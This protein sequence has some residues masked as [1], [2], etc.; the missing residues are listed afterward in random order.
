MIRRSCANGVMVLAALMLAASPVAGQNDVVAYRRSTA[1]APAGTAVPAAPTS[2]ADC[3]P[4]NIRYCPPPGQSA[5]TTPQPADPKKHK[6]NDALIAILT[7]VAIAGGAIAATSGKA[8]PVDPY[9]RFDDEQVLDSK[10]PRLPKVVQ[11]GQF[12]VE[13]YVRGG[14]PLVFDVDAPT[15][16]QVYLRVIVEGV[17]PG[18]IPDYRLT[19]VAAQPV[20]R[21]ASGHTAPP[22]AIAE[23]AAHGWYGRVDLP[24]IPALDGTRRAWLRI[25]SIRKNQVAPL[26]VYAVGAG[27]EAVGSTAL[28]VDQ[29]DPSPLSHKHIPNAAGFVVRF[30]N[31]QLF[32]QL[33]AQVM[34]QKKVTQGGYQRKLVDSFDFLSLRLPASAPVVTGTW[35]R[36]GQKYPG[37]GT[38]DLNVVTFTPHGAW[39]IGMAPTSVT[40]Q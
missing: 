8:E 21:A 4:N 30:H 6:N 39:I 17:A 1:T 23:S 13:G 29:F 40:V 25:V 36:A 16:A 26:A 3:P 37:S 28:T 7:G 20:K 15:D 27:P 34:Q 24:A 2:A 38:Y 35:P 22:P 11:F 33:T 10:G 19:P 31:H 5:P 32:P 9:S 12:A 14:W 18:T